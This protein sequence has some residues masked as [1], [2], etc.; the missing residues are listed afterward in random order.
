MQ[1]ISSVTAEPKT[2]STI[3]DSTTVFFVFGFQETSY[4][5]TNLNSILCC[6]TLFEFVLKQMFLCI[7]DL[8]VWFAMFT[9]FKYTN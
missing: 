8:V 3:R 6:N 7:N 2:V 4:S 9:I 1:S 5:A